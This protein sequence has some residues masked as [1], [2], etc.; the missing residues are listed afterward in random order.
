MLDLNLPAVDAYG[1]QSAME[2]LRQHVDYGHWYDANKLVL[3]TVD[4]CQY[5][6][7]LNPSAGSLKV[8]GRLQRHFTTFAIAMPSATSLL[9]IYQT[10]LDGHLQSLQFNS[11]VRT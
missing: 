7:A 8:D 4:D 9:T 11:S 6:V 10:F 3:K 5:I 1:A 2:L